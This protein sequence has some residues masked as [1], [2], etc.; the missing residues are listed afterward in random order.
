MTDQDDDVF[1]DSSRTE[2]LGSQGSGDGYETY[3]IHNGQERVII[4]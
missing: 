4:R 1:I 3:E 2:N